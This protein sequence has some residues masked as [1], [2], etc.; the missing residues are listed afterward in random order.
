[1]EAFQVARARKG[2]EEGPRA[3]WACPGRMGRRIPPP[4]A[5]QDV[6]RV[7]EGPHAVWG[8]TGRMLPR[9]PPVFVD[10][11]IC[12]HCR[13]EPPLDVLQGHFQPA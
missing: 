1:M 2:S 6:C 7:E 4:F 10:H 11:E 9:A 12:E 13:G 5:D 3:I 8:G